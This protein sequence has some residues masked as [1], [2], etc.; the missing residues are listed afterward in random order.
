[1]QLEPHRASLDDTSSAQVLVLWSSTGSRPH[2]PSP[3]HRQRVCLAQPAVTTDE[4]RVVRPRLHGRRTRWPSANLQRSV[5]GPRVAASGRSSISCHSQGFARAILPHSQRLTNR[6]E[7]RSSSLSMPHPRSYSGFSQRFLAR[8]IGGLCVRIEAP[9]A[10]DRF[11]ILRAKRLHATDA[12]LRAIAARPAE[13]VRA[14][15]GALYRVTAYLDLTG[16][17]PTASNIDVALHPFQPP[18]RRLDYRSIVEAVCSALPA[19]TL[20]IWPGPVARAM[21]RTPATSGD[22]SSSEALAPTVRRNWPHPR[23]SRPLHGPERM[24]PYL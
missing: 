1:M 24:P 13:H 6:R 9:D 5:P 21:S 11:A 2:A 16:L 19:P 17:E 7:T 23:R 20:K 4:R 18:P 14:L 22:V 3:C 8:L 10:D 15:E 12:A